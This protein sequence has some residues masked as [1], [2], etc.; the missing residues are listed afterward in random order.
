MLSL[1]DALVSALCGRRSQAVSSALFRC[2]W[3]VSQRLT[4][5]K[6]FKFYLVDGPG[7]WRVFETMFS[8]LQYV[9]VSLDSQTVTDVHRA[10]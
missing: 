9:G 2:P 8:G 10:P 5:F 3:F 7:F 1:W 6:Y 4:I